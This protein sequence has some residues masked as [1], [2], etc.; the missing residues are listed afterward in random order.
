[1]R[2][3]RPPSGCRA[4]GRKRTPITKLIRHVNAVPK[5]S[6]KKI[7][8]KSEETFDDFV[9]LYCLQHAKWRREKDGRFGSLEM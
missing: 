8:H 3:P 5:K 9:Y 6:E 7:L 2:R 1:M 4:I